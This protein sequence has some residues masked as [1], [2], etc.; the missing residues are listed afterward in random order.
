MGRLAAMVLPTLLCVACGEVYRPVVIPITTTPP[1]PSN[2]HAVFSISANVPNSPGGA[3]QVDVTGDSILAETPTSDPSAP[4]LGANPTH[5]AITPNESRLFVAAAGS[6]FSGQTDSVASVTPAFQ[7]NASSG[8]GPVSSISLPSQKS[9][10]TSISETGSA[11]TVTL[12]AALNV[13]AGYSIVISGVTIPG[14]SPPTCN[15]NAYNG[16][17][18]LTSNNGTTLSYMNSPSAAG[19]AAGSGGTALVPTQPVFLNSIEST[20]MYVANYNSNSVFAIST[21]LNVV[22]NSATVGTN[23][24]SLAEAKTPNGMKLYVANQ[25][26]SQATSSI[27]SLNTVDLSANAPVAGFTGTNPVWL[28]AR[29]DGQKVYVLTQGDGQLVTIDT[30][31]DTVMASSSVGIGANFIFYDPH[32]N[33]LYVTNPTTSTVYVF[34]ATGGANDTPTLLR[35]IS[36][37]AESVPCP[38]G[39]SPIA[40]VSVTALPDG[41]RFYV[42]SYQTAPAGSCPDPMIGSSPA[43]VI[44]SVAV[45]DANS[46]TPK[47]TPGLELLTWAL[48]CTP[49]QTN[50]CTTGPFATNQF[51]VPP[52]TSCS[53]AVLPALYSPSTTRFRMFATASAD[54]SRV[55]VSVCD[56]GVI[57]VVNTTNSNIN[58]PGGGG[59]SSDTVVTDLPAAFS[60]G[61]VQS[62]G[63]PPN[64]SPVFLL[65]GQ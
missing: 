44:P 4:N 32:L 33:R 24:V 5:A 13:A 35:A 62:N 40:P 59:T 56:A 57:A 29:S 54:S 61:P 16:T 36:L 41:S 9:N 11:V 22:T 51:A 7:F 20:A 28:V 12:S 60:A 23:P 52:V 1:T 19:L 34:S 53:P 58:N 38:S 50:P 37:G 15:P 14:C 6:V 48:P 2:F 42:A 39:C 30:A 49:N 3:L 47:T 64:Q 10:I 18:T 43:C 8:F 27:S 21:S 25:G 63:L 46:L 45:F 17:F 26:T 55:Y 65:T 31:T